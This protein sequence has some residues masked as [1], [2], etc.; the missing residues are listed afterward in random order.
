MLGKQSCPVLSWPGPVCSYWRHCPEGDLP[1][2]CC[3]PVCTASECRALSFCPPQSSKR[4]QRASFEFR[5]VVLVLAPFLLSTGDCGP[6]CAG[7]RV[8]ATGSVRAPPSRLLAS[9]PS[10]L[11]RRPGAY[12]LHKPCSLFVRRPGAYLLHKPCN[13]FVRRPGAYLLHK[14]CSHSV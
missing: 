11:V 3:A 13:L 1:R 2:F 10:L 9:A 8:W 12:L 4:I 7:L 5:S 14:P 6:V